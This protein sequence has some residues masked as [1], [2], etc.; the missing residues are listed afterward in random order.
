MTPRPGPRGRARRTAVAV[1][2]VLLTTATGCGGGGGG[3]EPSKAD[4]YTSIDRFCGKVAQAARRVSTDTAAVQ[5]DTSAPAA[6]RFAGIT[7]SLTRFAGATETALK[8]LE[9][10]GVPPAF[11][12]YQDGT[13][14]GFRRF[15]AT[16]RDTAKDAEKDPRVLTRLERR[17][18]AV[19]LPDPPRE[20][21]QNAKACASFSPAG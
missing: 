7:R 3:G 6:E 14:K 18:N 1:T 17:L 2:L 8:D 10:T 19:E 15:I 4:Y 20:I 13:S 5:R 11:K 21:T 16:L 12:A 9:G